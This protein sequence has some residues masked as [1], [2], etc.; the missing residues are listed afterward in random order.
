MSASVASGVSDLTMDRG[1]VVFSETAVNLCRDIVAVD[2]KKKDLSMKLK[3]E[4]MRINVIR[5][6]DTYESLL[7]DNA[8][9]TPFRTYLSS[10]L[11]DDPKASLYGMGIVS[12]HDMFHNMATDRDMKAFL[13]GKK[14]DK[15]N[16]E[17]L[18]LAL[19]SK[20]K[21]LYE[22]FRRMAKSVVFCMQLPLTPDSPTQKKKSDSVSKKR[23]ITKE[24]VKN[25]SDKQLE[26]SKKRKL[27]DEDDADAEPE[28]VDKCTEKTKKKTSSD[29]SVTSTTSKRTDSSG[30]SIHQN[31]IVQLPI[32][33]NI[34]NSIVDL[35]K[36]SS[37]SEDAETKTYI[38]EVNNQ[39][40]RMVLTN[41]KLIV[42][43]DIEIPTWFWYNEN[44]DKKNEDEDEDDEEGEEEEGE[45]EEEEEEEPVKKPVKKTKKII[46]EMDEDED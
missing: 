29:K 37:S 27:D 21:N 36:T 31:D 46:D 42:D 12:D 17:Q 35:F 14:L 4:L 39:H 13:K 24:D 23:R 7:K 34:A 22:W 5:A 16:L 43:K 41:N 32:D 9:M 30:I 33:D 2:Y 11:S 3:D 38:I 10:F 20:R 19:G 28:F 25:A 8:F 44:D 1:N 26:E 45:Y 18:M 40:I 6:E 15:G